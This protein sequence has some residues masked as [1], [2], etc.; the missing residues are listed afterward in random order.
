[1]HDEILTLTLCVLGHSPL[2]TLLTV[3]SATSALSA[4]SKRGL[5]FPFD[6]SINSFKFTVLMGVSMPRFATMSTLKVVNCDH[7][8]AMCDNVSIL[9]VSFLKKCQN[10]A[11]KVIWL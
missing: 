3:P 4:N 5:V 8:P 10:G 2:R 1:M 6:H 9:L 7:I 11:I